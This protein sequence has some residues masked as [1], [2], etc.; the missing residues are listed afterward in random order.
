MKPKNPIMTEE[1]IRE[2]FS[3]KGYFVNEVKSGPC[4]TITLPSISFSLATLQKIGK[5][6]GDPGMFICCGEYGHTRLVIDITK[7]P[8]KK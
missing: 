4:T 5:D 2:Y 8:L 6:L 1:E 7:N 3:N